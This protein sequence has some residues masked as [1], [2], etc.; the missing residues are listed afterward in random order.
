MYD[1]EKT[2]TA[3]VFGIILIIVAVFAWMIFSPSKRE[4]DMGSERI[5]EL[6]ELALIAAVFFIVVGA[7]M[8]VLG[9]TPQPHPVISGCLMGL[10]PQPTAEAKYAQCLTQQAAMTP[11]PWWHFWGH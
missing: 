7:V 2:I 1:D 6:A 4:A 5:L 11:T 8:T 10:G 3:I 9:P